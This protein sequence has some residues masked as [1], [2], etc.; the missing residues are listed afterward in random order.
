MKID[1]E[2]KLLDA[3]K[4]W[5]DVQPLKPEMEKRLHGKFVLDFNYNSNHIEGNTLT[6]G[7]TEV[8]LLFGQA[9]GT[10]LLRYFEE[11]KAHNVCLKAVIDAAN[12]VDEP[13]TETFI[14]QLHGLMLREDYQVPMPMKEGHGTTYTVHAGVYKTRPNSVR[15][16]GGDIF[17]YASP[18]ET[19]FMM[20]QLVKWY[21]E[22]AHKGILSPI[23]LA[24]TFHYRYIRIH[25]FED[26]NGRIAR[27]LVNYILRSHGWPMLVIKSSLKNEYLNALARTDVSV[28]LNPSEGAMASP[29]SLRPFIDYMRQTLTTQIREYLNLVQDSALNG[30]WYQGE[31]LRFRTPAPALIL[32]TLKADPK[33]TLATLSKVAGIQRS[34][35]QK[36]L[37]SLSAKG[38]IRRT[39]EHKRGWEVVASDTAAFTQPFAQE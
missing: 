31:M 24:A 22:N 25:P 6:Y 18:E 26:G 12:R 8:L 11:M 2:Q 23:D 16:P 13:L 36:H 3:I 39:G 21:N 10:G 35:V 37:K 1:I 32:R 30:W 29:G 15:T 38:Y 7:Q 9:S 20:H 4:R 28:G 34:A 14:R 5:Q 19:P 17:E 27:L 33:A